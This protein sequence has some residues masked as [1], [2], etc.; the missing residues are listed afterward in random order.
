MDP[1]KA[2]K[3]HTHMREQKTFVVNGGKMVE[4]SVYHTCMIELF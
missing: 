4:Y 1:I 3:V 2:A